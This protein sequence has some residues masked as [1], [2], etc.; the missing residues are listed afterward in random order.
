LSFKNLTNGPLAG[1][2]TTVPNPQ[3]KGSPCAAWN[4]STAEQASAQAS[5]YIASAVFIIT[6]QFVYCININIM[7]PKNQA[8]NTKIDVLFQ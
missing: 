3:Y 6:S 5:L 1:L 8:Q 4:A 2:I 7:V